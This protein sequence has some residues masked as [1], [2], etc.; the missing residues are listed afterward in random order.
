[1]PLN[2]RKTTKNF[3]LFTRERSGERTLVQDATTAAPFII[4]AHFSLYLRRIKWKR[5]EFSIKTHFMLPHT[6]CVH[7]RF[8][9]RQKFSRK[10]HIFHNE[11]KKEEEETR[12]IEICLRA[13][14][15]F[16][17]FDR[18]W[19][20]FCAQT[21]KQ[22]QRNESDGC[23]PTSHR[24]TLSKI[25]F[26]EI[27]KVIT[28]A[29]ATTTTKSKKR[30]RNLFDERRNR[31]LLQEMKETKTGRLLLVA[32][33]I[34]DLV[35]SIMTNKW[36]RRRWLTTNEDSEEERKKKK[37]SCGHCRQFHCNFLKWYHIVEWNALQTAIWWIPHTKEYHRLHVC[38]LQ[39]KQKKNSLNKVKGILW[40]WAT[41]TTTTMHSRKNVQR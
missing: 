41:A 28:T 19:F 35:Q 38:I 33:A 8:L 29:T 32:K 21:Q 20:Y 5:R 36:R 27:A 10:I 40:W 9:L 31:F 30:R 25:G 26:T 17:V 1:M 18:S 14:P 15:I 12:T 22:L 39:S 13:M 4:C 3:F 16:I 2:D 34:V 7:F 11:S 23:W 37:W 6:F 24:L